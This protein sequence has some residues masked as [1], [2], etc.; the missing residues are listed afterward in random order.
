MK[1]STDTLSDDPLL[2]RASDDANKTT[3]ASDPKDAVTTSI[4]EKPRPK[5][6][7]EKLQGITK[8][9]INSKQVV[10]FTEV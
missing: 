7:V 3:A 6:T 9:F 8:N 2:T 4:T 1:N 5:T 10:F